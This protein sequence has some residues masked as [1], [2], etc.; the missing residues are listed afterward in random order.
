MTS[1]PDVGADLP[2]RTLQ[3][4]RV[5]V[6]LIFLTNGAVFGNL[7]PRFPEIIESLDT[8]LGPFGT[9]VAIGSTGGLVFG[10]SA[11]P[12]IRRF[13]SARMAVGGMIVTA[14]VVALAGVAPSLVLFAAALFAFGALD[15][16]VDVAQN[17]HGLRVQRLYRRSILNSFH[18]VW[19]IGA[20]TGGLMGGAAAGL[21]MP[22]GWHLA[23]SAAIFTAVNLAAYPLLLRGDEGDAEPAPMQQDAP[24]G[25]TRVS[26]RTWAV[27]IALGVIAIGGA[28]VEDAGATWS[29]TYL[30][31]D[32]S[33]GATIAALG[34]VA[35]QGFQFIGRLLGDGMVD[36]WGQRA[37]ARLGGAIVL[38]GMGL[39]LAF[40]SV[41]GT[42]LGF[43]A[44]GF[45]VA[46]LIPSAMH[47]ADELPGF[48]PGTGLTILSVILRL[49]FL[50]SPP[51]V[52]AIADVAGLRVGLLVM[53]IA[54]ALVFVL[55]GVMSKHNARPSP[56]GV[57]PPQAAGLPGPPAAAP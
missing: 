16:V 29:A 7:V 28:W 32:L 44:A 27:L 23:T 34:F 13:G 14:I 15:A 43:G 50:L 38:V 24:A 18:A 33:A 39:A 42:I 35:L 30:Q 9:A 54:G 1:T 52:G 22:V 21:G 17:S 36:R 45:G 6:A 56:E 12:L 11:S 10:L 37:I 40:P 25:R 5:G 49:G 19:S 48:K 20:V 8:R 2:T 47:A 55:A 46:T 31:W 3:R 26:G 41:W 57:P 53:P 51:V 4:A